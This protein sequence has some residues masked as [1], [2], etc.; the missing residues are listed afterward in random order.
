M[1]EIQFDFVNHILLLLSLLLLLL[2]LKIANDKDKGF[3]SVSQK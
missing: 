2:L 1:S 3:T